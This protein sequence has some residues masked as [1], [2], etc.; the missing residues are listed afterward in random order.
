[1]PR[2]TPETL[3]NIVFEGVWKVRLAMTRFFVFVLTVDLLICCV[4]CT[5]KRE[6]ESHKMLQKPCKNEDDAF[7]LKINKPG[8]QKQRFLEPQKP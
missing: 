8:K 4:I 6:T 5:T 1:M 2:M 7:R 3:K